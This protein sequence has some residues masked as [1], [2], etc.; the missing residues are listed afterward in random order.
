[1]LRKTTSKLGVWDPA[2]RSAV[3]LGPGKLLM[4][5]SIRRH[6]QAEVNS[7]ADTYDVEFLADGR[8]YVCPLFRFQPRTEIVETPLFDVDAIAI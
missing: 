7:G 1:M 6:N 5:C 8:Q 4:S 3:T 2:A